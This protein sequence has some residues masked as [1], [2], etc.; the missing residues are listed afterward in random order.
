MCGVL[1]P[2]LDDCSGLH[3]RSARYGSPNLLFQLSFPVLEVPL[4]LLETIKAVTPLQVRVSLLTLSC[5]LGE[6]LFRFSIPSDHFKHAFSFTF[7]QPFIWLM[8][9]CILTI[10][11]R[12]NNTLTELNIRVIACL[13]STLR[14]FAVQ[15]YCLVENIV[16]TLFKCQN[17]LQMQTEIVGIHKPY[18]RFHRNKKNFMGFILYFV[19]L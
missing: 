19:E 18:Q 12:T 10:Q 9:Q 3:V 16:K 5:L 2:W 11:V 4:P 13:Q 8:V 6:F 14:S 15:F 1:R 7:Y 17:C